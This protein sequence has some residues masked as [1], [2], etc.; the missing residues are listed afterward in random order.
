MASDKKQN[1]PCEYFCNF[2]ILCVVLS[3][4]GAGLL[5]GTSRTNCGLTLHTTKNIT[6][7]RI[8]IV[9]NSSIQQVPGLGSVIDYVFNNYLTLSTVKN[10]RSNMTINDTCFL[11]VYNGP[12]YSIGQASLLSIN[13]TI[14][15]NFKPDI[16]ECFVNLQTKS[17]IVEYNL[18]IAGIVFLSS[19]GSVIVIVILCMVMLCRVDEDK[20]KTKKYQIYMFKK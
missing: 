14:I 16:R 8:G 17:C 12:V 13:D 10:L 11:T 3:I 1:D 15:T 5:G 19:G 6:E 7:E 18:T 20:D 2:I 4:I 9:Y